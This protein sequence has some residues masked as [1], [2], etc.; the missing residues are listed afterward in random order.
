LTYVEAPCILGFMTKKLD[1]SDVG[2][3]VG[4]RNRKRAYLREFIPAVALYVIAVVV[5]VTLGVDSNVKKAVF[6]VATFVPILMGVVAIARHLKRLDE[7][8][9]TVTYRAMAVAFGAAM[10][11]SVFIAL[12]ASSGLQIDSKVAAW[13]PF[14]VGM[15]TWAVLSVRHLSS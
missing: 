13:A 3:S 10:I 7:F 15:S 11:V 5:T 9:R 2:V 12:L 6:V 8:E 4:D 1:S 14:M